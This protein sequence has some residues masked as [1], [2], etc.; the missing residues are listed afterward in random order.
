MKTVTASLKALILA[1]TLFAGHAFAA[2]VVDINTAD[3]ATLNRVL[4]NVGPGKAQAIVDYRM[5]NGPF[6]SVDQLVNVRGIGLKTVEKNAER[7]TIGAS[8]AK[9]AAPAKRGA[10][11]A[12]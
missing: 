9:P 6:K 1:A 5:A 10:S 11:A 3:A 4:L 12:R 8:R 7:M 2:E